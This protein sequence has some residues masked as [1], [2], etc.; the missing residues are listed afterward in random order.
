[1]V[2]EQ[3]I[4]RTIVMPGPAGTTWGLD[5][6]PRERVSRLPPFTPTSSAFASGA[7]EHLLSG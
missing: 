3:P 2:R 4:G 6:R 5:R 7:P 1:M